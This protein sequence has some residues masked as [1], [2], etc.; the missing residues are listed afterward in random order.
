MSKIFQAHTKHY[1]HAAGQNIIKTWGQL[2]LLNKPPQHREPRWQVLLTFSSENKKSH[3]L[4][5]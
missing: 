1:S 5:L 4:L 3:F 2:F